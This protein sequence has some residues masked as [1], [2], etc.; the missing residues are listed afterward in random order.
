MTK[1]D[2]TRN[3]FSAVLNRLKE[4]LAMPK[5][6][7]TR[8]SAIQRFEFTLDLAWKTT[9]I[10]LEEFRGIRCASPKGCFREAFTQGLIDHDPFWLDLVDLRNDTVHTYKEELAESVFAQLSRAVEY[11]D[12]LQKTLEKSASEWSNGAT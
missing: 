9:K 7:V 12:L 8:D 11:F 5:T 2:S 3:D 4:V 1:Y 10:F 6:T